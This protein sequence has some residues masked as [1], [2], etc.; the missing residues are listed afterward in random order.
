[1][2]DSVNTTC[3]CSASEKLLCS[4]DD[5]GYIRLFRYPALT[6]RV[7]IKIGV[8]FLSTFG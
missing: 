1:M 5:E 3:N 4:A 8:F 7:S 2:V 6:P